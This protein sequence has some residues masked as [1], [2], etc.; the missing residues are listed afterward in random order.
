M[1]RAISDSAG[2]RR[3]GN[4]LQGNT[5]IVEID[6]Y[7]LCLGMSMGTILATGSMRLPHRVPVSY[8]FF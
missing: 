7:R 2:R 5:S 6:Q 8:D 4:T 1:L 3:A